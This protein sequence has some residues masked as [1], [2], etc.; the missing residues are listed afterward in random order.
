[1]VIHEFG[2]VFVAQAQGVKVRGVTLMMLGGASEMEQI[3][4]RPYGEFKLAIIGPVVS[5][6]LAGLLLLIY[7]RTNSANLALYSY[8]LGTANLVLGIFNLLPALPLDGGRAL[9][10]F[11]AVR[12]GMLHATQRVVGI[13]RVFAWTLG[14][15]AL[16]SFNI[17]LALIAFYIYAIAQNELVMLTTRRLIEGLR[18]SE[19]ITRVPPID[20]R[21]TLREAA[22]QMLKLKTS[23]LPVATL[24]Q[25]PALLI[26]DRLRELPKSNWSRILVK[27]AKAEVAQT[28]S[29]DDSVSQIIPNLLATPARALPVKEA[30]Q[31]IGVVCYS[32]LDQVI[33]FKSLEEPKEQEVKKVA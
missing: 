17:L 20:E 4:E 2:H 19:I 28:L 9:R 13:S 7:S 1:V 25:T 33:Q 18:V 15:W 23:V 29:L 27:D 16:L 24:S 8:W 6:A 5:F 14:I 32:D 30:N 22:D 26:L 21:A 31:L 12:H 3:P 11:L 10:S